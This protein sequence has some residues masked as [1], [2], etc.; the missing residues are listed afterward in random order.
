MKKKENANTKDYIQKLYTE[1][2][3]NIEKI[4]Y[5]DYL[6]WLELFTLKYPAFKDDDWFYSKDE[7]SE[8][9]YQKV[10]FLYLLFQIIDSYA[11]KNYFQETP[12][13]LGYYYTIKSNETYFQIG[14]ASGQGSYIYCERL[15]EINESFLDFKDIRSDKRQEYALEIDKKLEKLITLINTLA[16]Q[17][18]PLEAISETTNKTIQKILKK[19]KK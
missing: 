9:D 6:E 14:I 7:I 15:S 12:T 3:S 8:S 13:K 4:K 1:Y 11:Q 5:G 10:K 2:K 19:Q 16:E 17:N 18:T